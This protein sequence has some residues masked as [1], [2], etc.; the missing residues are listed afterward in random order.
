MLHARWNSAPWGNNG[1]AELYLDGSSTKTKGTEND[2]LG[3]DSKG[4]D[5]VWRDMYSVE[6]DLTA[7]DHTFKLTGPGGCAVD[8]DYFEIQQVAADEPEPV[9]E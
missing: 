8:W 4:A 6:F 2:N 3:Q 5:G 1:A 7:G 9:V